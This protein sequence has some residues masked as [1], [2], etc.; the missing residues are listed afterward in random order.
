MEIHF[1]LKYQMTRQPYS[2][3]CHLWQDSD[4]ASSSA[5]QVVNKQRSVEVVQNISLSGAGSFPT[6]CQAGSGAQLAPRSRYRRVASTSPVKHFA[7]DS[8]TI[9]RLVGV[10]P[11]CTTHHEQEMFGVLSR[12]PT[13]RC[14]L[15][16]EVP[17]I[18][19]LHAPWTL[20]MPPAG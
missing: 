9:S 8:A 11:A 18:L 2:L 17:A 20:C 5:Q 16:T 4:R 13:P 7:T 3:T 15:G 12:K 19:V 14:H 10:G 6:S 1:F